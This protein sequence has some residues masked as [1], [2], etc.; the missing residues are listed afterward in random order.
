[1]TTLPEQFSA[2]RKA[3]VETQLDYVRQLTSKVVE[4]TEKVIALNLSTGRASFEKSA[5]ALRQVMSVKD[6]RDLLALTAQSQTSFESVL[7]YGR[8]LFSIASGTQAELIKS[9]PSAAPLLKLAPAQVEVKVKA[10][11]PVA[12]PTPAPA[13]VAASA[14]VVAPAPAAAPAAPAPALA[15]A[16]EAAPVVKV[17]ASAPAAPAQAVLD[18]VDEV[19]APG[20]AVKAKPLAKAVEQAVEAVTE[21]AAPTLAAAAVVV[22]TPELKISGIEPVEAAPA[23]KQLS[24]TPILQGKPQDKQMDMLTPKS[25]KKK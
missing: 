3:Q 16:P 11:A 12:A 15:S 14:P 17:E 5:A 4:S 9:A 7:A 13:P 19:A 23:P 10:P 21:A 22:D 1:M 20:P 2:A 18:A 6:P 25:R 24:G 8:A